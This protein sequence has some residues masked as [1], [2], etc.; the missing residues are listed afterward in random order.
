ME[1][2]KQLIAANDKAGI[3]PGLFKF[4]LSSRIHHGAR[5]S[6]IIAAKRGDV[7]GGLERGEPKSHSFQDESR[8]KKIFL[9]LGS[10]EVT[11]TPKG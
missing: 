8:G 3:L 5:R 4:L 7:R 1:R 11:A 2:A 6:W 10:R 9:Y